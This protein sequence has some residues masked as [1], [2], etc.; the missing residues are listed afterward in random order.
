MKWAAFILA[1]VFASSAAAE[2]QDAVEL[3]F[4][5]E[6]AALVAA[7]AALF[8]TAEAG[9]K[10]VAPQSSDR[11]LAIPATFTSATS[12]MKALTERGPVRHLTGYRINWY[13]VDRFL[14][15]VDFMGTWNGNRDLVCGYVVWDLTDP[16]SPT[17]E[18]VVANYV[19]VAT[20]DDAAAH[21][22][23]MA[24]LDANCAYG[25]IAPNFEALVT[26]K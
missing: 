18:S 4:P 16:M 26:Q 15:A 25:E 17:L 11:F 8:D 12:G 3:E 20:L 2:V 21:E 7:T 23:H 9:G 14:G 10:D 6:T 22:A 19:D 1:G 5:E 24:L 13:P